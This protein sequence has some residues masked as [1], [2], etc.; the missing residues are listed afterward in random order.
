MFAQRLDFIMK[1]TDAKAAALGRA[2]SID[3]SHVC[4]LRSGA[5]ML[6]KNPEFLPAMAAFFAGR[7][8]FDHQRE[9]LCQALCIAD[10]PEAEMDASKLLE[11][12]LAGN[13]L[14]RGG[15]SEVVG[16]L[17][18]LGARMPS[19]FAHVPDRTI[20]LPPVKHHYFGNAGKQEA[21]LQ[22]FDAILKA[23][24][25]QT[26]LLVSE[27]NMSWLYED[28]AF[29]ARWAEQF[30][31]VIAAGNRVRIIHSLG[32]DLTE[33]FEA[34]AKWLPIYMTGAVEPYYLPR[35]RDGISKRTLFVAPETCALS[36]VSIGE[37]TEGMLN[38]FHTDTEAVRA[39][40]LEFNNYLALCKPLMRIA[41]GSDVSLLFEMLGKLV[42]AGG[43]VLC[44]TGTPS[45]AT[46]PVDVAESMQGRIPQSHIAQRAAEARAFLDRL[47]E[48]THVT[49]IVPAPMLSNPSDVK[50]LR[51]PFAGYL[52]CEGICYEKSELESHCREVE[53]LEFENGSF[54][55][56]RS[57][58]VPANMF[59]LAREGAGAVLVKTDAPNIAFSFSEP[60]ITNAFW[61]YLLSFVR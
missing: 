13:E 48:T 59:V 28:P 52:G 51:L 55:I 20:S 1:L 22:F 10:W 54:S 39:L 9:A 25:P 53:R 31:G 26:I 46:M 8:Q 27:E 29:T 36:S 4:R 58:D 24:Q 7:V 41:T 44:L 15:V 42:P 5:R 32:R 11:R 19:S 2:I 61:E 57:S 16:S 47:F 37:G 49:S 18:R 33:L 50:Q 35:L 60:N 38:E 23:P 21:V 40:A 3:P 30:K 56:V 14:R 17:S 43:D 34:V 45:L 6:P 12:W